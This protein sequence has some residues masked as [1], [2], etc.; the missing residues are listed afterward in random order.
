[1]KASGLE[2]RG[3]LASIRRVFA[4]TK[5]ASEEDSSKGREALKIHDQIIGRLTR[6]EKLAHGGRA[7]YVGNNRVLT[8]VVIGDVVLAFLVQADDRLIVPNLIIEGE[9]EPEVTRYFV[10]NVRQ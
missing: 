4:R 2:G 3:I 7:T 8:K 10:E 9:H 1:M 5:Q 6:L